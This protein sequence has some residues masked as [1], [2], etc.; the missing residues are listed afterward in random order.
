METDTQI[1]LI[2]F[3]LIRLNG[4]IQIL[5]AP[6]TMLILMTIM[7]DGRTL[8]MTSLLTRL[9]GTTWIVTE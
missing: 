5:M 4:Q 7:M 2:S 6:E 3:L 1:L 8:L 9:N